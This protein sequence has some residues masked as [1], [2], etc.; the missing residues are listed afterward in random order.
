MTVCAPRLHKTEELRM[1]I[2]M[3]VKSIQQYIKVASVSMVSDYISRRL[4]IRHGELSL[5]VYM[6]H[7]EALEVTR[8]IAILMEYGTIKEDTYTLPPLDFLDNH[9]IKPTL[10]SN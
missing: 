7:C 9:W 6:V 3:W 1:E 10:R 8:L 4:M 5:P 2:Q